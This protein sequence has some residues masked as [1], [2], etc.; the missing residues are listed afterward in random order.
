MGAAHWQAEFDAVQAHLPAALAAN[1][2]GSG[3]DHVLIA[4]P[5]Y[6]VGESL[7][8][9]YANRIPSLEHRYLLALL[10][11]ARVESC[12]VVFVTCE[13]PGSEVLAYYASLLPEDR[14]TTAW[15]RVRVL[16]V[17]DTSARPVAAKLFDRPDLMDE[18]RRSIGT[19]PALIEA[20]NVTAAEVAVA[21]RLGVPIN[22]S[23]PALRGIAFKSAG[24][25]LLREAGVPVP[26]GCEDV[27]DIDSL[28]DAIAAIRGARPGV[29]AVVI[30]LDDSGAGDGNIIVNLVAPDAYGDALRQR[31]LN[32]PNWYL[33]DLRQG[34]VVEELVTG[35]LSASP[36]AQI[37]I[38]PSGTALVLATHEQVLGG[39]NGQVY[40]GCRFPADSAYAGEIADHAARVGE[41][42]ARRGAVGRVGVDFV[43]AREATG[44][45]SVCGLEINLRKGGTTHPYAALR[46]LVPGRYDRERGVWIAA[47]GS[48]RAYVSTD[49]AVDPNWR[50]LAPGVVIDAVAAAG[51]RFDRATGAGVVLHMLSGLRI[52][53]RFGLTAIGRSAQHAHELYERAL[54]AVAGAARGYKAP[55]GA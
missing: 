34:A 13:P 14:R 30:K 25:R 6:S 53:G 45:W 17:P 29:S 27:R 10:V 46:C 50:P 22:G 16:V 38:E 8:S 55:D 5:S 2:P 37:D 48:N 52:D 18:L 33:K 47:D 41:L 32:L 42:L 23:S 40:T 54:T 31:L 11:V 39:D 28:V 12:E 26:F 19:R 3:V 21:C 4:M 9:H 36:S 43:A 49:N 1:R 24:R 20:W 15:A 35:E 44:R 7:L 51:L